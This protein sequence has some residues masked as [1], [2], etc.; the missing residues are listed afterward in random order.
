M[1]APAR[2]ET[3][4]KQGESLENTRFSQGNLEK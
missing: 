4:E 3:A 1:S 2:R